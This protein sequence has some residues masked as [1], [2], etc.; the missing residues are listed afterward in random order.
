VGSERFVRVGD[1]RC[2][3]SEENYSAVIVGPA[4]ERLL[5]RKTM[6]SWEDSL[7]AGE[8]VRVHRQTIVNVRH[9]KGLTRVTD[10]VFDLALDGVPEPVH[11]SQRYVADLRECMARI[12]P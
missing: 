5:V 3:S 12:H 7:P 9:A 1:I 4:A 10:A 8:F 2:I 6:R 11:A